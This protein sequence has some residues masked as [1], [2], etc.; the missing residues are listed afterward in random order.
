M[1]LR[2]TSSGC[3]VFL[4]KTT[5]RT[6]AIEGVVVRETAK[7]IYATLNGVSDTVWLPKSQLGGLNISEEDL[8]DGCKPMRF[9]SAEIPV[10][11]WNKLPV[12]QVTAQCVKPW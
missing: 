8:N 12:N 10:W 3:I 2:W 7:A 9:L 11:L 1:G 6:T 5:T 4:M